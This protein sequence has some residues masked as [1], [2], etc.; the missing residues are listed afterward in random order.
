MSSIS[1]SNFQTS[2][3]VGEPS[4]RVRPL[5]FYVRP[6]DKTQELD[7]VLRIRYLTFSR[8]SDYLNEFAESLLEPDER[9]LLDSSTLYAAFD[10]STQQ[11]VGTMRIAHSIEEP[12]ALP[13]YA[14]ENPL[15]PLE[16]SYA[17]RFSVLPGSDT[18]IGPALMKAFWE[19]AVA[20]KSQVLLGLAVR[21]LTRYYAYWGAFE[22]LGDGKPKR[23]DTHLSVPFYVVG[24]LMKDI[25]PKLKAS[26][27]EYARFL[28]TPH[29]QIQSDSVTLV[30]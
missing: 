9:D 25:L 18:Y 2:S 7:A 24:A 13:P 12:T 6:I 1:D 20:K 10:S 4:A 17:D 28:M 19:S 15:K 8:H 23:V 26:N 29:A 21:A 22:R 3:E 30:T 5:S 11:M 16:F 27:P 14:G